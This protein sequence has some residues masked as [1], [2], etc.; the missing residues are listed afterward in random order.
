MSKKTECSFSKNYCQMKKQI[1][2]DIIISMLNI[3]K[4]LIRRVKAK[5]II[6]NSLK[7]ISKKFIT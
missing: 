2:L 4:A 7:K 1:F 5:K 3:L 6:D